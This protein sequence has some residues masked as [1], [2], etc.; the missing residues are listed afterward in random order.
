MSFGDASHLFDDATLGGDLTTQL[1]VKEHMKTR[2]QNARE[3]RSFLNTSKIID[4]AVNVKN[5]AYNYELRSLRKGLF[6]LHATTPSFQS[7]TLLREGSK[8]FSMSKVVS[9][10][11]NKS[12]SR[13]LDPLDRDLKKDVQKLTDSQQ[14]FD[15]NRP[16]P[17]LHGKSTSLPPLE[18]RK[19]KQHRRRSSLT[20]LQKQSQMRNS[21]QKAGGSHSVSAPS[22]V[23]VPRDDLRYYTK[24]AINEAK[25]LNNDT[26]IHIKRALFVSNNLHKLYTKRFKSNVKL[27]SLIRDGAMYGRHDYG[28]LR[29]SSVEKPYDKPKS[30]MKTGKPSISLQHI[31]ENIE[32]N[33]N[34][35][36]TKSR[37]DNK[38]SQN[39]PHKSLPELKKRTILV[40]KKDKCGHSFS[41]DET[42]SNQT[43]TETTENGDNTET[44]ITSKPLDQIQEVDEELEK[45]ESQNHNIIP[46]VEKIIVSAGEQARIE[47]GASRNN[48]DLTEIKETSGAVD[49]ANEHHV[50]QALKEKN[51]TVQENKE[52]VVLEEKTELALAASRVEDNIPTTEGSNADVIPRTGFRLGSKA[53]PSDK[54]QR[55]DTTGKTVNMKASSKKINLEPEVRDSELETSETS[56]DEKE[57]SMQISAL[58][59]MS[60]RGI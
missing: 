54:D 39:V 29:Q 32:E 2:E 48:I 33:T 44:A 1:D 23:D 16:R 45:T 14:K 35:C 28:Y 56:E 26:K 8:L 38:P 11:S 34:A 27:P 36:T 22:S 17:V 7:L 20:D 30:V 52:N 50:T 47:D 51:D 4:R 55:H 21:Y 9:Y 15:E 37:T 58:Q 49:K 41:S 3:E 42:K 24:E 12:F 31:G 25:L 43:S 40:T 53:K 19:S 57:E 46:Q 6:D 60:M 18:N 5:K 59:S 10:K 13:K